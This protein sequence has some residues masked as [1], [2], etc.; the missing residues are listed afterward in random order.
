[1]Y[2]WA[3]YEERTQITW[4]EAMNGFA[5]SDGDIIAL[6]RTKIEFYNRIS[7]EGYTFIALNHLHSLASPA[8]AGTLRD[9]FF[10]FSFSYVNRYILEDMNNQMKQH[11]SALGRK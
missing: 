5:E 9:Y 8:N 6:D 4:E 2:R 10:R 7:R 11:I 1:M 3:V